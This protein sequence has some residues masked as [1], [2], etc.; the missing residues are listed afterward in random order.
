MEKSTRGANARNP[1]HTR[2]AITRNPRKRRRLASKEKCAAGRR[3]VPW[4]VGE[5]VRRSRGERHRSPRERSGWSTQPVLLH[6]IE[7]SRFAH[8]QASRDL[9]TVAAE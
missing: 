4:A 2:A 7:E 8:L 5:L 3:V 6:A 9:F 1:D